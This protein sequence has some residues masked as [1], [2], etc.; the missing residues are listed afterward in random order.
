VPAGNAFLLAAFAALTLPV[1]YSGLRYGTLA[2]SLLLLVALLLEVVGHAGKALLAGNPAN[3]AYS[4]VYL[5][6]T[7]WGAVLTGSAANL[8]LPHVFVIYGQDFQLVSDPAYIN[9]FFF[10]LDVFMLVFQSVGI[11]LASAATTASKVR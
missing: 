4:A 6:G 9:I 3:H 1:L 11:G 10:V 7:H 5:M 2:H 8:V